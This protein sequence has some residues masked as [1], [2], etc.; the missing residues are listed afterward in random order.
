MDTDAIRM[1]RG[2]VRVGTVSAT[3]PGAMA[4]RVKFDEKDG[5]ISPELPVLTTGSGGNKMYWMPDVGDEV[6]CLFAS[7]DKNFTTGWI[8]GGYFT[9]K[10]PPNAASQDVR[11]IDFGDGS[12]I[13]FNRATGGL[14]INCNGPVTINGATINLN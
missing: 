12:Y 4:A 9:Q 1:M 6:V 14:S 13:E 10:H 8:V 2:M 11:R 7:N 5:T 3:N